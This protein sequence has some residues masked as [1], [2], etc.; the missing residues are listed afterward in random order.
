[1]QVLERRAGSPEL[2]DWE[3]TDFPVKVLDHP[4]SGRQ[5]RMRAAGRDLEGVLLLIQ[6]ASSVEE[7]AEDPFGWEA[8]HQQDHKTKSSCPHSAFPT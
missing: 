6:E 7:E 3:E 2:V 5:S 4:S 8:K 1:M